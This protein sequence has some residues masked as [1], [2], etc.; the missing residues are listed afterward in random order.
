MEDN[1]RIVVA[2]ETADGENYL[3]MEVYRIRKEDTSDIHPFHPVDVDVLVIEEASGTVMVQ[4]NSHVVHD[5]MKTEEDYCDIL[6]HFQT[7][8]C[9]L[10]VV[11]MEYLMLEEERILIYP[12]LIVEIHHHY[13]QVS[14]YHVDAGLTPFWVDPF[15][16]V[17]VS[18]PIVIS[19]FCYSSSAWILL[20]TDSVNEIGRVVLFGFGQV[21]YVFLLCSLQYKSLS[22]DG[23]KV[24]VIYSWH[25]LVLAVLHSNFSTIHMLLLEMKIHSETQLIQPQSALVSVYTE[26]HLFYALES[27]SEF[28][29]F[30]AVEGNPNSDAS[31]RKLYFVYRND[32]SDPYRDVLGTLLPEYTPVGR[33]E[34]DE[35]WC[36]FTIGIRA[37]VEGLFASTSTV[38]QPSDNPH[39]TTKFQLRLGLK[40]E[41]K[42]SAPTSPQCQ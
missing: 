36:P 11:R 29:F 1:H 18:C 31:R 26:I 12:D 23:E 28:D 10:V 20:D 27:V 32:F 2:E 8:L 24:I 34:L 25:E 39:R 13:E 37:G 3:K 35:E 40:V 4:A 14:I 15:L 21:P 30:H 9:D 22:V 42:D 41:A 17:F 38:P 19:Y 5:R 7:L 6:Y 33:Y 16:D